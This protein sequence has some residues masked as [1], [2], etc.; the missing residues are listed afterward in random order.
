[1]LSRIQDLPRF[2]ADMKRFQLGIDS[3]SSDTYDKGLKLLDALIVAVRTFD[4]ATSGLVQ[5]EGHSTH[6]DHVSAQEAVR[7]AKDDMES[8][9]IQYAPNIHVDVSE[10][11]PKV[12]S[13][14]MAK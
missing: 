9:M 3:T 4:G 10:F 5:K 2:K 7:I 11:E 13:I 1:M 12:D 14:E 8:W 6:M